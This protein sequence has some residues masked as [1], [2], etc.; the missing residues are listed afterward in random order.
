MS[1]APVRPSIVP[2]L[3]Y[4]RPRAA[5]DWLQTAFGFEAVMVVSGDEE[6][7]IHS[8]LTLGGGSVYVV[9]PSSMGQGGA[10]PAQAGGRNTQSVCVNLTEGLDALCEQARAAGAKIQREPA[11]QPYGDRVFTCLD[12]EGHSWAFAQP[13][14]VMT[15]EEIAAATGRKIETKAGAHG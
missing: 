2:L 8:E 5:I 14:Q 6:S 11:D 12:P 1:E 7:V 4:D 9:G 10:T 13:A 3:W 15:A